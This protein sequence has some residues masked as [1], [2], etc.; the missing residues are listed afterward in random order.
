MGV[1]R[2]DRLW[3]VSRKSITTMVSRSIRRSRRS[4]R[5]KELLEIQRNVARTHRFRSTRY[6]S[7]QS[8]FI[9]K[10]DNNWPEPRYVWIQIFGMSIGSR[11]EKCIQR[12]DRRWARRGSANHQFPFMYHW[13]SKIDHREFRESVPIWGTV[14]SVGPHKVKFFHQKLDPA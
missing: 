9:R 14:K 1:G 10:H 7:R 13:G 3:F 12:T 8:L 5:S 2:T 11:D 4:R 6:D